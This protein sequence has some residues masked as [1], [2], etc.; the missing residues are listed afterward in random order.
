MRPVATLLCSLLLL[1]GTILPAA[2]AAPTV[3]SPLQIGAPRGNCDISWYSGGAGNQLG[4]HGNVTMQEC[5]G[6]MN[7]LT[8]PYAG[9]GTIGTC[10]L[11]WRGFKNGRAAGR[12][13]DSTIQGCYQIH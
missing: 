5:L 11:T 6:Q 13:F 12:F 10:A 8:D 3:D 1:L 7:L 4:F 2:A 9:G